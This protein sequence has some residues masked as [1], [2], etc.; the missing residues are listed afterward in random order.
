ML[1]DTESVDHARD[2]LL[3]SCRF[4]HVVQLFLDPGQVSNVAPECVT[5]LDGA[6]QFG[7]QALNMVH[8]VVL[9]GVSQSGQGSRARAI[10]MPANAARDHVGRINVHHQR[11]DEPCER[12]LVVVQLVC[13][14]LGLE[15]NLEL[16][17]Q[18]QQVPLHVEEPPTILSDGV[19]E[20]EV[21]WH[22]LELDLLWDWASVPRISTIAAATASRARI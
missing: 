19:G 15:E 12:P 17:V 6:M 11:C 3:V 8:W 13:L 9:V 5:R 16:G 14:V 1:R 2:H 7:L 18:S 20:L 22:N 21:C 4:A 10:I